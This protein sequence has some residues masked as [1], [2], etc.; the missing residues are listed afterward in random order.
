MKLDRCQPDLMTIQILLN[1]VCTGKKFQHA[2][3]IFRCVYGS[4]LAVSSSDAG[5][6]VHDVQASRL[7]SHDHE[8]NIHSCVRG[9]VNSRMVNSS[10][11]LQ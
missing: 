8:W 11:L 9:M 1:C 3:E 7:C 10:M 5:G 6:H 4:L 2:H